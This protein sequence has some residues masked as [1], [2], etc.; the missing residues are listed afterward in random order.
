MDQC[1]IMRMILGPVMTNCYLV[2]MDSSDGV[3]VIDPA[4]DPVRITEAAGKMNGQVCAILLT[5]GHFDHIG[6]VAELRKSTG[7]KVYAH[8]MEQSVLKEPVQNLSWQESDEIQISADVWL[9]D[10]MKVEEGQMEFQVL[11]TPGH[12]QGGCCYYLQREALLFSG[13]TL[14]D[15]SVGRT[16]FPTGSMSTLVRSIQ[17]KLFV[18]PDE[19]RVLPGHGEPTMI[20]T[21]KKENPFAGLYAGHWME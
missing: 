17:D 14:F 10:G 2:K 16:D 8:E 9:R 5:H 4:A 6:A 7:A 1:R 18:L 13:D 21:E 20:G 12:T 11:Y 19:T 3:V 15:H